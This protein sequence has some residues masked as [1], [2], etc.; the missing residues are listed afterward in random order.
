MIDN[1]YKGKFIVFEGI[2]G[3]GKAT[4][5]RLLKERLE[6][7]G[8]EVNKIDFPRHGESPAFF[9]D[10]YLNGKYGTAEEVGPF[11]GSIFY[12]LD[13]Y[14]ASFDIKNWLKEGKIILADRYV[15]SNVGHQGGKIKDKEKRKEFFKWLY[16]L[17]Y[18][19]FEIPRPDI[20]FILKTSSDLSLK[21]ANN[22]TDSEKKERRKSY[23][24]DDKNQDIHEKDSQHLT[25]TLNSYLHAAELFPEEFKVIECVQNQEMLPSKEIHQKIWEIIKE[26]M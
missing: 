17:E 11:R 6:N 7:G 20:T 19:L 24:G 9:V 15:A 1:N 10:T 26:K 25:D 4:Q 5:V 16:D 8:F 14:D 18:N 22:I 2:D 13:R 21:M 12:T 3:S 23:L